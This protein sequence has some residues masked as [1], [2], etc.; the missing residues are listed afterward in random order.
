MD[1]EFN[2]LE[3]FIKVENGCNK[4]NFKHNKQPSVRHISYWSCI[5]NDLLYGVAQITAIVQEYCQRVCWNGC[6][7]SNIFKKERKMIRKVINPRRG[8]ILLTSGVGGTAA[9]WRDRFLAKGILRCQRLKITGFKPTRSHAELIT[10]VKGET[11]AARWRTRFRF[12]G[13]S[14]YIGS[15]ITIIRFVPEI[16]PQEYAYAWE[17]ANMDALDGKIYP[18]HR[19]LLMGLTATVA[20]DWLG[21]ISLFKNEAMCSEVVARFV[22][23]VRQLRLPKSPHGNELL[24]FVEDGWNGITPAHIEMAQHSIGLKVVYSGRLSTEL[25]RDSGLP[26]NEELDF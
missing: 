24:R 17:L 7:R 23:A 11:F 19:I 1:V 26:T 21:E 16:Q 20:P 25:M 5:F 2:A 3:L 10:N 22:R 15:D 18:V 8:D 6:R 4:R 13:L 14:D 9:K 12:N